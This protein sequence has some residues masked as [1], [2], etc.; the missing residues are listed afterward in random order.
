MDVEIRQTKLSDIPGI[1]QLFEDNDFLEKLDEEVTGYSLLKWLYF[2]PPSPLH[3]EM[4]A[5]EKDSI[6]GHYGLIPYQF[7]KGTERVSSG[8]SSML[9]IG[10]SHRNGGL[11]KRIQ[12]KFLTEFGDEGVDF[13]Y[14]LINRPRVLKIHLKTGYKEM[15]IIPVLA[16]P[17]RSERLLARTIKNVALVRSI[18]PLVNTALKF[19][20][21][22]TLVH[23]IEV[24]EVERFDESIDSLSE[25][26]T[27]NFETVSLRN[28][29]VLNWRFP[30]S[31]P[32]PYRLF[33]ATEKGNTVGI[34]V[35][36]RMKMHEFDSLAIADI[37]FPP[38]REE[39]G[40]ALMG[41]ADKLAKDLKIDLASAILNPHSPYWKF[42]KKQGYLKTPEQFSL[43]VCEAKNTKIK[44]NA[45]DFKGWHLSWFDHDAV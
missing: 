15:G 26:I 14:T 36:R 13:I 41:R 12:K 18:S 39:V 4:I 31:V 8:L 40:R 38:D 19:W 17:Y 43:L 42:F 16:K 32:R 10:A 37:L 20:N 25:S 27:D 45:S 28:A 22:Q 44:V 3:Y 6:I 11:F 1:V 35:L 5:T 29:R 9:L 21:W 7:K 33:M 30:E 34:M 23:G 2:D 24:K